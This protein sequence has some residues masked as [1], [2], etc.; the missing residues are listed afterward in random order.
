M[1]ELLEMERIYTELG[2]IRDE[3]AAVKAQVAR[4]VERNLQDDATEHPH[5]SRNPLMHRGE[6]TIR[7]TSITV[8]TVVQRSR[9]GETPEQIA[10]AYPTLGLAQIFD[11]LG[12]YYDH[13][14][15]I[16][17]YIQE[18]HGALWG[19]QKLASP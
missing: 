16:E 7:N 17:G 18:N 13:R 12:Y 15:E 6:P 14:E 8:R 5:I 10:E 9:L 1:T 2:S 11:A 19:T 4:F 3:L